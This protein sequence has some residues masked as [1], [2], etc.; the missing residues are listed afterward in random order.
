M[1][2]CQGRLGMVGRGK[3]PMA[4]AGQACGRVTGGAGRR[5]RVTGGAGG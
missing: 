1:G 4:R 3:Q 5:G 2:Q